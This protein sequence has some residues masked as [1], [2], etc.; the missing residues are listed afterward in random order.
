M[1]LANTRK[2]FSG[3]INLKGKKNQTL[4]QRSFHTLLLRIVLFCWR[5]EFYSNLNKCNE[6]FKKK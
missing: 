3:K 5:K 1:E 2:K 4:S 6:I